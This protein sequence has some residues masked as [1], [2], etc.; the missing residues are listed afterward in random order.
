M[1]TWTKNDLAAWLA[2]Y[3]EGW[4]AADA[5]LTARCPH[6]DHTEPAMAWWAG[7]NDYIAQEV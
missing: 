3:R 1:S 6:P 5:G 2:C 4:W 7:F